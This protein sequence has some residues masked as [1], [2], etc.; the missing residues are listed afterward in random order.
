VD[1]AFL[2][3]LEQRDN[4]GMLQL[5]GCAGL[6]LKAA[7]GVLVLDLVGADQLEGDNSFQT[8]MTGAVDFAHAAFAQLVQH[9]VGPQE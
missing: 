6:T 2:A 3:V 5:G 4:V 9:Y 1:V 7:D 8:H